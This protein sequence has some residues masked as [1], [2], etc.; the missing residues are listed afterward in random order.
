MQM[1]GVAAPRGKRKY[2]AAKRIEMSPRGGIGVFKNNYGLGLKEYR[3]KLTFIFKH[4]T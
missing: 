4:K 2:D 3:I 1:K